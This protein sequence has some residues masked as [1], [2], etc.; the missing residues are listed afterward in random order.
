[1]STNWYLDK[2]VGILL[3]FNMKL[4]LFIEKTLILKFNSVHNIQ[5][6]T[7]GLQLLTFCFHFENEK[8][9]TNN[10]ILCHN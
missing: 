4:Y 2:H 1:M 8:V 9:Q 7:D 6:M 5:W 10:F 3:K